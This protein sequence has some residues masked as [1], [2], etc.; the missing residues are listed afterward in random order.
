MYI[1]QLQVKGVKCFEDVKIK[2][3]HKNDN[4]G[5]WIVLLGGNGVGKSTLLQTL[6][7]ACVGPVAGQRL[8]AQPENWV[9]EEHNHGLMEVDILRGEGDTAIGQPRQKPYKAKFAIST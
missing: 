2:F 7:I 9:R 5:G 1:K 8:L 3:P 6:A 4:Y